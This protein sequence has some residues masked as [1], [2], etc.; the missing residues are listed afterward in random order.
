M[1]KGFYNLSFGFCVGL[2]A[3]GNID[4]VLFVYYAFQ[5]RKAVEARFA[6]I[7]AHAARAETAKWHIRRCKV[8]NDV[9]HTAA[10]KAQSAR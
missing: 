5:V 3:H 10:A 8:N 9:V 2:V 6:V 7:C 1:K 4:G